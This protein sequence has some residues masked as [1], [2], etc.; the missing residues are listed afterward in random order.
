[1]WETPLEGLRVGGSFQALELD[2]SLL[3]GGSTMPTPAAAKITGYLGLGSIEYARHDLLLAAE[4]GR[5][6]IYES[7]SDQ[8]L[9]PTPPGAVVSEQSYVSASYRVRSWL[10]PAAYYA[11]SFPDE[12]KR[13]GR[14]NMLLDG[15]ACVRFDINRYWIVKLEGHYM[16]GTAVLPQAVRTTAPEDW[17]LFL[18]KTTAY[19]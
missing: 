3:A 4:Y 11:F 16:H 1:M 8:T 19:F 13:H 6:R 9:V 14:D 17:S 12:S 18:A 15:A 5:T 7:S 2:F 10:Q